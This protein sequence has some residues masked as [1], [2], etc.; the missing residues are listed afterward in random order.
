MCNGF[1]ISGQISSPSK[2]AEVQAGEKTRKEE[3][4]SVPTIAI[5]PSSPVNIVRGPPPL[6]GPPPPKRQKISEEERGQRKFACHVCNTK[7]KEVH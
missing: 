6:R 4:L 1:T 5:G 3:S 2:N 7:F